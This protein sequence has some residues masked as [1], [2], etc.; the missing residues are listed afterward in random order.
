MKEKNSPRVVLREARKQKGSQQNVAKDLKISRQYL[1]MMEVG[2]RNPTVKL[3]SK[4]ESYFE[5]PSKL[6]FPDLFFDLNCHK[7]KQNKPA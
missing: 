7:M 6:L 4:M 5:V 1:G 2:T 3:M